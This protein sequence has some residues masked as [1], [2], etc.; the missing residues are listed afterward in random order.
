[1]RVE[2]GAAVF[3]KMPW[4]LAGDMLQLC[5]LG[6]IYSGDGILGCGDQCGCLISG[7]GYIYPPVKFQERTLLC[8]A[9]F[10][11]FFLPQ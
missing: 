7:E 9:L 4:L 3:R 8:A 11:I 10:D 6:L 2:S 5:G 1:M